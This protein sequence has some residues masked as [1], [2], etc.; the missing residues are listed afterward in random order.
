MS[1]V[2]RRVD[3]LDILLNECFCWLNIV[4]Y[5]LGPFD[6]VKK[7]AFWRIERRRRRRLESVE[8]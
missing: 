3:L 5:V 7:K 6:F 4:E 8:N 2:T 1:E